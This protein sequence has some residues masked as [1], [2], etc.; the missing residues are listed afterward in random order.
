[1]L[2]SC[3]VTAALAAGPQSR[4]SLMSAT[5]AACPD[6][7]APRAA[8]REPLPSVCHLYDVPWVLSSLLGTAFQDEVIERED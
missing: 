6:V 3:A 4:L 2:R 7:R 8:M 5:S 1:M